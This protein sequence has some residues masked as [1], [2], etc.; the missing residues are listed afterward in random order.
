MPVS[1][2]TRVFTSSKLI[3]M[4]TELRKKRVKMLPAINKRW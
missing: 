1:N 4:R 3:C 2:P